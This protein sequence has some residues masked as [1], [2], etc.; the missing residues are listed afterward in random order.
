MVYVKLV[1][2]SQNLKNK[3]EHVLLTNVMTDQFSLKT[4]LA[5]N[6]ISTKEHRM[7][8]KHVEETVAL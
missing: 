4:V 7:V 3:A 8:E 5:S 6:A 2:C 1:L